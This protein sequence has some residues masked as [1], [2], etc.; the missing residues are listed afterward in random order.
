MSP[1]CLLNSCQPDQRGQALAESL[2]AFIAIIALWHAVAW[3]ARVQDLA[4]QASHAARF[5]AFA[6]ARDPALR[7]SDAPDMQFFMGQQRQWTD[8]K[9]QGLL[10]FA[11]DAPT[12]K[13]ESGRA[14]P[15]AA[16]PGLDHDE[17]QTLRDQWGVSDPG[18]VVAG[19]TLRPADVQ[20][21]WP[22]LHRELAIA[23]DAGHAGSDIDAA[24]RIRLS[25]L[26]WSKAVNTSVQ[27]GKQVTSGAKG[28]D[29]AWGRALP[30]FDWLTPWT[31]DVPAHVVR[32]AHP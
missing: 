12:L 24:R 28:V 16:Q 5:G 20:M 1:R 10:A 6:A 14:L 2:V 19:L 3:L 15:Q 26:G 29:A 17:S 22:R 7:T 27:L 32:S 21:G 25:A 18:V 8:T 31:T 4:L 9:G 11:Y 30:D 23:V 13:I